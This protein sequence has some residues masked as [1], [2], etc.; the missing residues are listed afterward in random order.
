MSRPQEAVR[1]AEAALAGRPGP[2]LRTYALQAL[3]IVARD[4]GQLTASL[5]HL[6]RAL[7]VAEEAGLRERAADVGATLGVALAQAGRAQDA[8]RAFDIAVARSKGA[9]EARVRVR[10]GGSLWTM[11]RAAEAVGHLTRAADALGRAGDALW[12]ARAIQ[13]RG[14]AYLD[15]GQV[16]RAL[17]DF[18]R[19]RELYAGLG[20][21]YEAAI[22]LHNLAD[23]EYRAG[24]LPAA[25]GRYEEAERAYQ[26]AG[27]DLPELAK[28]RSAALLAAGLAPEAQAAADKAVAL[29]SRDQ[30]ARGRRADALLFASLAAL[31]VGDGAAAATA[32]R[33][34]ELAFRGSSNEAGAARARLA[35]L[36]AV[37]RHGRPTRRHVNSAAAV[38]QQ[39][40][41]ARS[42][43][44]ADAH[45]VAG[46]LAE[47]VGWRDA[48]LEHLDTAATK[49]ASGTALHRANAWYAKALRARLDDDRRAVLRSCSRGL[50][51]LD[52][53]WSSLGA[54]ELRARSTAHGS[55][56]AELALGEV[57]RAG[58]ARTLLAWTERWR[59][60]L[61]AAAP[62]PVPDDPELTRQLVALRKLARR[63]LTEGS[64]ERLERER[65]RLEDAVRRHALAREESV[66][67]RRQP[68]LDVGELLAA[69]GDETTLLSVVGV[70][71]QLH[72]V[73]VRKGRLRRSA[74]GSVDAAVEEAGYA[75]FAL[76]GLTARRKL[77]RTTS[78]LAASLTGALARIEDQLLGDAVGDLGDGPVVLIPPA[79]LQSA[80]WG[81]LP[82]LQ[83]RVVMV[84]PSATAWLRAVSTRPPD[85]RRV[86]LIAGPDLGPAGAE[87][88]MLADRYHS[89][90]VLDPA[91]ATCDRVLAALDGSWLAHVAAHG[92]FRS[93]NPMFSALR[94]ADG[95]LTVYDLERLRRA[96]YRL[97]L[98][99]CESGVG[100]P[101]GADELLGLSSC[102]ISLGTAGALAS[103]VLVDNEATTQFSLEIHDELRR[104]ASLAAALLGARR[105][106]GADL[107]ARATAY[108]FVAFGAA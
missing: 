43:E 80:P 20:Q 1:E 100:A 42:P 36:R 103:V 5:R 63:I 22:A 68:G 59:S 45:L 71:G 81:A 30:A 55:D 70:K 61:H 96:P 77:Q 31:A 90:D 67:P 69:V 54:M 38:E 102:L 75:R 15:L 25:L 6:R 104:G 52:E 10:L 4:A 7:R 64:S 88:P 47:A 53:H 56:L 87:V 16:D 101:I 2:V 21:E 35:A 94:L 8:L 84:A 17:D 99:A 27:L 40:Q 107:A 66:A 93:D 11:G 74:A 46:Q 97:V 14:L 92:T 62:P 39:L 58:S 49:L 79:R 24:R 95:P 44:A 50:A 33:R 19:T 76:R 60:T 82:S 18:S 78:A 86:A 37:L 13:F 65:R 48:A 26:A 72:V 73:A 105:A 3:G 34:A 41:S 89:A 9:A 108:S 23:A 12:Q 98:S 85:P 32:A 28:D 51:V 57:V 91:S 106:A 29:L 83:G